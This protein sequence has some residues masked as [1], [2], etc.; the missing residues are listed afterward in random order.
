MYVPLDRN[1]AHL[2]ILP[3][4]L[5]ATQPGPQAMPLSPRRINTWAWRA[6]ERKKRGASQ[7]QK[8]YKVVKKTKKKPR[9]DPLRAPDKS[10]A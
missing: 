4:V 2:K 1:L 10:G 3:H 5:A 6:Q 9:I 8:N 7:D